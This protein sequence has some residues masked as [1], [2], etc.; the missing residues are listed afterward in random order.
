MVVVVKASVWPPML[1]EID[2]W[3]GIVDI[4]QGQWYTDYFAAG[5]NNDNHTQDVDCTDTIGQIP[6]YTALAI[7]DLTRDNKLDEAE[8]VRFVNR[9]SSN[10]FSGANYEDLPGNLQDNFEFFDAGE[11]FINVKGSTPGQTA[12]AAEVE[13][14]D[15][16]CCRTDLAADDHG[17]P[18][19][20]PVDAPV[21][22]PT[23]GGDGGEEVDCTGTIARG[24]CSLGLSVADLSRDNLLNQAEYIGFLNRLTSNQYSGVDFDDLPA[25][26]I[27]NYDKFATSAGQIDVQ[28]SK[29]GQISTEAQDEHLAA[30]CCETDLT[31][32]E[33][34]CKGYDATCSVF[35]DCCS[36]RCLFGKC[37][38][39]ANTATTKTSLSA[40]NGGASGVAKKG[41]GVARHLT[42]PRTRSKFGECRPTRRLL[43][44]MRG[45]ELWGTRLV[46]FLANL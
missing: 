14:L 34:T 21:E 24:Q 5:Q 29:P 37:Q 18:V 7:A 13:H 46:S 10:A 11:G 33:S 1:V 28:G 43:R 32:D 19:A 16:L 38:R 4:D 6:C 39:P 23:G 41:N 12:T 40:G 42:S 35:S 44:Q 2:T 15:N 9:L 27:S 31:I 26:L 20:P 17:Q 3:A 36:D 45:N 22:S 8:Y 25:N 30:F